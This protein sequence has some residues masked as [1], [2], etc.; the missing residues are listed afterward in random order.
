MG[1]QPFAKGKTYKL[2]LATQEVECSIE[3]L[4]KVI[5][6]STLD[7]GFPGPA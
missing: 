2:K 1:R 5:D 3:S 7:T 6:A 4:D